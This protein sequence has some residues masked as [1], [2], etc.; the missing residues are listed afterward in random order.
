MTDARNNVCLRG[1]NILHYFPA[2]ETVLLTNS[3]D[4]V[5]YQDTK[6]FL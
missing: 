4:V 6:I 3:K 5:F 1:I 2:D